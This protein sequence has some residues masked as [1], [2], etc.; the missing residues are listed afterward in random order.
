M[1]VPTQVYVNLAVKDL[2]ASMDFFGKL[3]FSFNA[4]FTNDEAACLVIGEN[5]YVMLLPVE[6]FLTFTPNALCDT[7]RATEVLLCF[8]V[9]SRAKVD[10]IV[11]SAVRNGGMIYKEPEDRGVMYGHGFQDPDGHI[12]EVITMETA[13]KQG[14]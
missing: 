10:E 11:R 7:N 8:T 6:R 12:W 4:Q 1:T 2:K 14:T 5:V 13:A 9:E 3:G